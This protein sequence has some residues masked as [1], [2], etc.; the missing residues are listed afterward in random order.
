MPYAYHFTLYTLLIIPCM[1]ILFVFYS[2]VVDNSTIFIVN[3]SKYYIRLMHFIV[4]Y[5]FLNKPHRKLVLSC[6]ILFFVLNQRLI[7]F[8][9]YWQ[10]SEIFIDTEM[11]HVWRHL[12][13][14]T[15]DE[16]KPIINRHYCFFII[17][18]YKY[19]PI[20]LEWDV[21]SSTYFRLYV[22]RSKRTF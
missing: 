6:I 3:S 22:N 18:F 17:I 7:N 1:Q 19:L 9:Y 15:E 14:A 11:Q 10:I 2:I 12:N 8:Y 5:F 4:V 20:S 13:S 16:Q 21:W